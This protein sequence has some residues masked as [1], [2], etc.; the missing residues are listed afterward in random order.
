MLGRKGMAKLLGGQVEKKATKMAGAIDKEDFLR[1]LE[2]AWYPY[3]GKHSSIE[4]EV[5]KARGRISKSGAFSKTFDVVGVTDEDLRTII[6]NIQAKKP[7]QE[8]TTGPKVGRNEPCPCGSGKKYKK[9][10]LGQEKAKGG[11]Q[12]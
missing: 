6:E 4:G 3:V 11:L 8:V 5:E 2:S 7:E 10:C 12:N 9:C 1:Q